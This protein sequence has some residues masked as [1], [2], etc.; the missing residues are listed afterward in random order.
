MAGPEDDD[1]SLK[2]ADAGLIFR[3]EVAV[4]NFGLTYW[5]HMLVIVVLGLLGTLVLGQY[6]NWR[7]A[8][9]RKGSADVA[10]ALTTLDTTSEPDEAAL[11][12]TAQAVQTAALGLGGSARVAG[13][14]QSAE[15]FRLGG[16]NAGRRASLTAAGEPSGVLGYSVASGLAAVDL[17][18]AKVDEAL[19]RYVAFGQSSD[20]FIAQQAHWDQALVLESLGRK[21]EA[22]VVWEAW[23]AAWPEAARSLD[24]RERLERL[25]IP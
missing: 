8:S 19:A 14:L 6:R 24:V 15:L 13:L 12:A 1:L 3:A 5:R 18:D 10:A 11:K 20:P 7:I 4:T 2:P 25:A 23:L 16:D 22:K 21:A 17:E 9:E